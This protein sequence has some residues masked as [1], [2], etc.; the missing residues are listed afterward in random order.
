MKFDPS[1]TQSWYEQLGAGEWDRWDQSPTTKLREKLFLHHLFAAVSKGGRVLDAGCGAGRFTAPMIQAGAK[2]TAFDLSPV[3]L[4]LARERA[5]GAAD[6]V[7]GSIT[8][9]GA[10][11]DASF[12]TTVC[13]GGAISY[14]FEQ[15][16][17]AMSELVRVTKP[18]GRVVLSVLSLFGSIHGSLPGV[19]QFDAED[20]ERVVSTG[21]LPRDFDTPH[22]CHLYRVE[23]LRTLMEGAGFDEVVLAAPGF[24]TV[25]HKDLELPKEGTPEYEFL[26]RMELEASLENPGGGPHIIGIGRRA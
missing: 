21:D 17:R 23:E 18:G 8:D 16:G 25:A 6:Y 22:E 15:A 5:P 4:K 20:N 19:L 26:L 10:F 9:L 2:V 3:Q 24:L 13:I 12:D 11:P 1:Y 14:T 7:Q